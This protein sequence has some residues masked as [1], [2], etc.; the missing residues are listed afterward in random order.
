ATTALLPPPARDPAD[1][2]EAPAGVDP[3]QPVELR[4]G[5]VHQRHPGAHPGTVDQA[6]QRPGG[7]QRPLPAV[8]VGDVE[9]ETAGGRAEVRGD[10]LD[11][12][13]GEVLNCGG[14]DT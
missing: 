5:Q 9:L 6:V 4:D 8:L 1:P 14:T 10:R 13:G 2:E 3:H 12:G 11:A 7:V